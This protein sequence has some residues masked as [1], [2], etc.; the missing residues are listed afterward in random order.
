MQ[1]Q[2][3]RAQLKKAATF[4]EQQ[5]AGYRTWG[6]VTVLQI[7]HRISKYELLITKENCNLATLTDED[8]LSLNSDSI[9]TKIFNKRKNIN[10]I[11]ITQQEYGSA[12]AEEV[13]PILDDQAQ[14]LGVSIKLAKQDCDILNALKG[15]YAAQLPNKKCICLG[16]SIEEAYVAAQLLEKTAKAFI[17]AKHLGGAKSINKIE[18]WLMQQFYQL[19]YS[20]QATK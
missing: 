15:R 14:L 4:F 20:K 5:Q 3:I 11:L 17:E 6:H 8:I 9:Y 18:A 19:K 12:L 7:A 10:T 2:E 13:P 1:E 16:T